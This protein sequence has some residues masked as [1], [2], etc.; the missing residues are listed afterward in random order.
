MKK[1]TVAYHEAGHAV[2]AWRLRIPLRRAGVTIVPDGDAAGSCSHR[3]I[4]GHDIEWDSSDR[5]VFRA[6]RLAQ[7]CLAGGIAQ[8]RYCAQ[9]VRR[10]HTDSDRSEAI[11]VMI[12]L[13]SGREL[14]VWLKLLYIRTENML[15]NQD[16]WRAV[17]LLAEALVERKTIRAKEATEIM[18]AGFSER[19]QGVLTPGGSFGGRL[20]E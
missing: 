8:R 4:V 10:H 18:Y 7:I 6:E 12:H 9:S 3:K 17:Q 13:A 15:A 2:V 14:E 16:V 1:A 5:I 19:L 11:D 20:L